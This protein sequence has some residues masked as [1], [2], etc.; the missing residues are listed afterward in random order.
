MHYERL[1]AWAQQAWA[2]RL[3]GRKAITVWAS[4]DCGNMIAQQQVKAG[5]RIRGKARFEGVERLDCPVITPINDYGT[6]GKRM[7]LT[8]GAGAFSFTFSEDDDAFTVVYVSAYISDDSQDL[9]AIAVVPE[10]RL[11]VW[12]SFEFACARAVRPR[13]RRR[14]DV[15]IV[16]GTDS[17]FDPTVDWS[18]VILSEAV[19]YTHLRAHET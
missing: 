12:A 13:I 4:A 17:F 14:R 8:S 15:Y 10:D 5:R 1:V 18:D 2:T 11:E 16:G 9:M 6:R 19:S 3:P 7:T